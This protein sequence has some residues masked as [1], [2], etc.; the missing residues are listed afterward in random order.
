MPNY[1]EMPKD[2][3]LNEVAQGANA[4]LELGLDEI[5]IK[6]HR[7]DA[8]RRE[9]NRLVCVCGHAMNKH[10]EFNPGLWSCHTARMYCPCERPRAV[11]EVSDTRYF[12][13]K[14]RGYGAQHA[15]STG[16]SKLHEKGGTSKLIIEP[17]CFRCE[18]PRTPLL[19]AAFDR[20]VRLVFKPGQ[21]N[22]LFCH[23]CLVKFPIDHY[24]KN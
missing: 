4:L 12:M 19:P 13:T 21:L 15:L 22:G 6:A 3:N 2:E 23:D 16:L 9:F 14:S 10:S 1:E 8:K 11:V 7:D 24:S 17:N 20:E 18:E 5:E